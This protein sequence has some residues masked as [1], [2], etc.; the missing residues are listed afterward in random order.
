MP[1]SGV[2]MSVCQQIGGSK[3]SCRA[4]I[5]QFH[6]VFC[7][8]LALSKLSPIHLFIILDHE[9]ARV[10]FSVISPPN[11]S[12]ISNK[13]FLGWPLKV[14]SGCSD[15]LP[16]STEGSFS[17]PTLPSL[18]ILCSLLFSHGAM[19][20][21][22]HTSQGSWRRQRSTATASP[23]SAQE[24]LVFAD[25]LQ[26]WGVWPPRQGSQEGGARTFS[27]VQLVCS[28]EEP[29]SMCGRSWPQLSPWWPGIRG[30]GEASDCGETQWASVITK[31]ES[32]LD[33][34]PELELG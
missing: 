16:K 10:L 17:P 28:S 33:A 21:F 1:A 23:S 2:H 3:Q 32:G 24:S 15:V 11:F 27:V 13:L 29:C 26:G 9:P 6:H 25:Q 22:P 7:Q 5:N 18:C 30:W 20:K 31:P 34:A 19:E 14:T 8:P 12:T 4:L